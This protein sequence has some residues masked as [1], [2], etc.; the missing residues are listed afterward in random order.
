MGLQV[1]CKEPY[2]LCL[3]LHHCLTLFWARCKVEKANANSASALCQLM[4]LPVPFYD[5]CWVMAACGA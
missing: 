1:P 3:C 2:S 5:L 4:C